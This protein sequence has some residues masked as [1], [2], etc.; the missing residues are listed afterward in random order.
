MT[1]KDGGS[2]G[3]QVIF[4]KRKCSVDFVGMHQPNKVACMAVQVIAPSLLPDQ[5]NWEVPD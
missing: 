4:L 5:Q 1:V 3:C 2:P